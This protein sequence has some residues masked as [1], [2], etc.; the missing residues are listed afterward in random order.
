MNNILVAVMAY[1]AERGGGGVR[2]AYELAS[3]L[4]YWR[5][6]GIK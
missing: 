5:I 3:G 6:D 2:L 4:A 1:D